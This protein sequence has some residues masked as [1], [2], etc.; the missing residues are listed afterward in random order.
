MTLLSAAQ[1]AHMTTYG[2]AVDERRHMVQC[3]EGD[4]I[5]NIVFKTL[6][7]S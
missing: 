2:V 5:V 3:A 7:Q 6:L 1:D 4:E